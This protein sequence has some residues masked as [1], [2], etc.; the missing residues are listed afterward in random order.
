M[1]PAEQTH[2]AVRWRRLA[3]AFIQRDDFTHINKFQQFRQRAI[4]PA[5]GDEVAHEGPEDGQ[6]G[7]FES[8][9]HRTRIEQRGFT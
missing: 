8:V 4:G 2:P 3:I 6:S 9:V 5:L 1:N 7:G